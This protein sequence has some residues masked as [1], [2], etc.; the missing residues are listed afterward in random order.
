MREDDK[1]PTCYVVDGSG[2]YH[3]QADS[4]NEWG[5]SLWNEAGEEDQGGQAAVSWSTV[6]ADAIPA[7]TLARLQAIATAKGLTLS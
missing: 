1:A 6:S 4:D 2:R 7:E 5:F 3:I